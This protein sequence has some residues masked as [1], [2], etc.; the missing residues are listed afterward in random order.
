MKEEQ[1]VYCPSGLMGRRGF[2]IYEALNQ[3]GFD[4]VLRDHISDEYQVMSAPDIIN[5]SPCVKLS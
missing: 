2:F 4:F 3:A 1:D 5:L